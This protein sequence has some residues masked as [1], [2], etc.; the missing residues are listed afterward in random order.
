VSSTPS[1]TWSR[2]ILEPDGGFRLQVQLGSLWELVG[3]YAYQDSRLRFEFAANSGRWTATATVV[4][5]CLAVAYDLEMKLD[6]FEDA[7]YCSDTRSIS[8]QGTSMPGARWQLGAAAL[9]GIVYVAGGDAGQGA[10][11]EASILAYDP[12]RNAWRTVGRLAHPVTGAAMAAVGDRLYVVGGC[13]IDSATSLQVFEPKTGLVSI[14]PPLPTPRCLPAAAVL[15]G[16]LHVMGGVLPGID[17]D[18]PIWDRTPEHDVFD[19]VTRDW[20]ARAPLP[21]S[22]SGHGAVALEGRIYVTGGQGEGLQVYD[23]ATDAWTTYPSPPARW[24]VATIAVART[25]YLIGG[26]EYQ[27]RCCGGPTPSAGVQRY[28]ATTG[29]WNWVPSLSEARTGHAVTLVDGTIYVIGGSSTGNAG[30]AL[31]TVERIRP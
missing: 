29:V 25:M 28:D 31:A 19:P 22:R 8:T 10:G 27:T 1:G 3:T 17:A 5:S 23:P 4:E 9:D 20:S 18:A 11:A 12:G 24:G 6:D 7:T 21:N 16:Q 30:G 15:Q 26:S 14:G 2:Y 13:P